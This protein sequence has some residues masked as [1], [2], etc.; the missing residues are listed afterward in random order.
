[1]L[2]AL[3]LLA[4]LCNASSDSLSYQ[5]YADQG[6]AQ[7]KI[8]EDTCAAAEANFPDLSDSQSN[9]GAFKRP[10]AGLMHTGGY[11]EYFPKGSSEFFES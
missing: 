3:G 5:C 7:I 4:S 8:W 2:A 6:K 1:M 11:G 9:S 10:F